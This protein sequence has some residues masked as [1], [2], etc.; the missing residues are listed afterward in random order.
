[1][2]R[3]GGRGA[4]VGEQLNWEMRAIDSRDRVG[5]LMKRF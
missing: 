5:G 1:M 2:C 3:I 4:R